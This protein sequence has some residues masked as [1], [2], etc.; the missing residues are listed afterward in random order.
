M[1]FIKVNRDFDS[2][3]FVFTF[4]LFRRNFNICQDFEIMISK[5]I[6]ENFGFYGKV[7]HFCSLRGSNA[8]L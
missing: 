7:P 4:A 6:S 8:V 1:M 3:H 2:V 5:I